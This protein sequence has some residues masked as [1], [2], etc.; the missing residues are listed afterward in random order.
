L[1]IADS[2]LLAGT[3]GTHLLTFHEPLRRALGDAAFYVEARDGRPVF[4]LPF[5]AG[6][7]LGTTDLPFAGDPATAVATE[8]EIEY[9]LTLVNDVLPSVRL[10]RTDVALHYAGVRPLPR[11]DAATPAAVTRRHAIVEQPGMP[12]PLWTLVGGKLTTCRALAEEGAAVVLQRL[13]RNVAPVSRERPIVD[14][15]GPP[16]EGDAT[17]ANVV[18]TPWT[19]EQVRQ[20]IRR[21]FVTRLDDLVERRLMLLFEPQIRRATLDDLATLLVAEGRLVAATEQAAVATTVARLHDHFGRTV[22]V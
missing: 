3:K 13:G 5:G 8:P 2:R 12:W 18:G 4:I 17:A 19:R 14:R 9:L 21:E 6:T 15:R 11:S 1:G 10:S 22:D 16:Q 7:L 20:I